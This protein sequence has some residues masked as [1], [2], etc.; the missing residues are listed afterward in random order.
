MG[1]TQT[2]QY[3]VFGAGF[4]IWNGTFFECHYRGPTSSKEIPLRHSPFYDVDYP[5]N[6]ECNNGT[7]KAKGIGIFDNQCYASQLTVAVGEEMIN[8][9]IECSHDCFIERITIGQKS[10]LVTQTPYPPPSNIHI[11][12]IDS[13]EI[14]FAWDEVTTQCSSLQYIITAIN[15]G[16]CPNITADKNVTCA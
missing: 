4:T 16:L 15:C 9:T 1:Y 6:G 11:E 8:G 2:F 5:A 13:S 7:V 12:S 3:T 10:L 14:T